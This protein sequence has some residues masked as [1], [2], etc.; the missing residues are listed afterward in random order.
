MREILIRP[1]AVA[2]PDHRFLYPRTTSSG[3]ASCW[4][5]GLSV[6]MI[7][8]RWVMPRMLDPEMAEVVLD[9]L[10]SRGV[11]VRLETTA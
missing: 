6:T 3:P 11:T 10:R 5:L 7:E 2:A 9:A 8:K 4:Q 1:L